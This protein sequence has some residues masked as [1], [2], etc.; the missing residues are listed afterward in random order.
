MN[1]LA[2]LA[3]LA[4]LADKCP[5]MGKCSSVF[6]KVQQYLEWIEN[7]LSICLHEDSE[8]PYIIIC[9]L[10]RVCKFPS[11]LF[12]ANFNFISMCFTLKGRDQRIYISDRRDSTSHR[13]TK[14]WLTQPLPALSAEQYSTAYSIKL[15]DCRTEQVGRGLVSHIFVRRWPVLSLLS[16]IYILCFWGMDSWIPCNYGKLALLVVLNAHHFMVYGIV[17]V[18]LNLT[19]LASVFTKCTLTYFT[20][21]LSVGILW[22]TG[23]W[24]RNWAGPCTQSHPTGNP[25]CTQN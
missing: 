19:K 16:L 12:V 2:D 21:Y 14:M 1:N 3:D 17:W 25:H 23:T 15:P 11:F 20:L 4:V 8:Y 5:S 10:Y 7:L 13:L 24:C 9:I 18:L 6:R 22:W